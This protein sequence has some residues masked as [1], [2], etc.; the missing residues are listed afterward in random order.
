LSSEKKA[1]YRWAIQQL[2]GVITVNS[3]KEPVSI[4]TDRELA[5][6]DYINTQFPKSI[7][8]LC[9]WH[10]NINVLAKTK[11]HF[12]GPIKDSNRTVKRHPLFQSF[13]DCWNRLLASTEEQTYDNLLKEMRV[14]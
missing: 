5:L 3:I 4:V 7:H 8:L 12:P 11:R 1:D 2:R 9:R 10:V 13:L 6:I 14:V